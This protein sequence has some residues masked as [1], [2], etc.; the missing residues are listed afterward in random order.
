M[1][2]PAMSFVAVC[3]NANIPL[4]SDKK[5]QLKHLR[6]SGI[7]LPSTTPT[8]DAKKR[9]LADSPLMLMNAWI[10]FRTS[11][12]VEGNDPRF[13]FAHLVEIEESA[14]GHIWILATYDVVGHLRRRRSHLR[15]R[16]SVTTTS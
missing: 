11:I 8:A 1:T 15:R 10:C 12:L 5:L 4:S 3:A 6:E 13:R 7:L 16:R 9:L 2:T 14:T